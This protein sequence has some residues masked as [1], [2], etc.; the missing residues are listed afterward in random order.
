VSAPTPEPWHPAG[1]PSPLKIGW[2]ARD[3]LERVQAIRE[4]ELG[5]KVTF[6]EVIE[7]LVER[8]ETH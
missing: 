4:Q 6:S 8:W 7:F 3:G 5:R 1:P 2:A